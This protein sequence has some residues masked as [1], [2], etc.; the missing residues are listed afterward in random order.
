M[1]RVNIR[2]AYTFVY[3]DRKT[4]IQVMHKIAAQM[5]PRQDA[6]KKSATIPLRLDAG[7]IGDVDDMAKRQKVSRNAMLRQLI[8]RGI[9]ENN[10]EDFEPYLLLEN[11]YLII[12][13]RP[14]ID[15][16]VVYIEEDADE[17][18]ILSCSRHVGKKTC[19]HIEFA[20][21]VPVIREMIKEAEDEYRA[22]T[23]EEPPKHN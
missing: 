1:I 5:K 18:I 23:S 14:L 13:E 21:K 6:N 15:L 16:V 3:N 11:K 9:D 7:I 8:Q 20:K 17:L 2:Y 22:G 4:R 10:L 19:S 12:Y